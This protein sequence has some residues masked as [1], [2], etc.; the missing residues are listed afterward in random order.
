MKLFQTENLKVDGE[1][2][3]RLSTI[4]HL[5]GLYSTFFIRKVM[6]FGILKNP[7][8]RMLLLVAFVLLMTITTFSIFV[9]FSETL[10]TKEIV[11]F[12]LNT[13]SSTVILWTIVVTIFLKLIFSKVDGFLRM[14]INFPISNKER[15]I[16][17]F[18]YE[19]LI[20]CIVIF[21]LSFSVVLSMVLIHKLAFID[22]LI[23]NLFYVSTFTYLVLQ[24]ISK[25]VSF[26]CSLLKIQKLFHIIN[27]SILVLFFAV[28][29]RKSEILVKNLAN[30]LILNTNNTKDILLFFQQFHE[31]SGF[32]L[33]TFL[34]LMLITLLISLVIV[35]PDQSYMSNSKQ[36]LV[37]ELKSPTTMK[38]YML[39]IFR[40]MNTLNNVVLIYLAA[41][42]LI[43]FN[44]SEYIL[45]VIVL[46]SFNAIYGFIYSQ[47]VRQIMYKLRY[48][49]WKDY[50]YLVASQIIMIYI[51]SIPLFFS[52]LLVIQSSLHLIIPYIVVTFS[53]LMFILAGILFPPYNDN[54]FSVVTS[55]LVVM[56]PILVIGICLTFL[57]LSL[58]LNIMILL[59]FYLV[60][61]SFSIQGLINL[62]R[63]YRN[64]KII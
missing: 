12:L 42:I 49:A 20:S 37:F 62:K 52:G 8:V 31:N 58:R 38:A 13:Y 54:P 22:I 29:L 57:N 35:I 5:V 64:E 32:M 51:I 25:I 50:L 33:T 41:L 4:K 18:I 46:Q 28:F 23:V 59:F 21:L 63:S 14:T 39:S 6:N 17:V 36:F 48:V 27:L 1:E 2:K 16:S 60:I 34:Y 19:T 11:L 61:V 26:L 3:M 9:F 55:I 24:V 15:N 44:L 47:N 7:L 56:I 45:Y 10:Q 40:H 43:I 53:I 30:D